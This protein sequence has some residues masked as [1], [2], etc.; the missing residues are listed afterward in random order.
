MIQR[1]GSSKLCTRCTT[2]NLT[3]TGCTCPEPKEVEGSYNSG[4]PTRRPLLVL[5]NSSRRRMTPPPLCQRPRRQEI[6]V[7]HQQ[8]VDEVQSGTGSVCN[9]TCREWGEHHLCP[10]NSTGQG[11]TPGSPTAQV[12]V[13]I[14]SAPRQIPTTGETGWRGP[15]QDPQMAKSSWLKGRNRGLYHRS[16]RSKP[17]NEPKMQTLWPFRR[18]HWP[19]GLRLSWTG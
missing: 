2:P 18:Y 13:D 14:K 4:F 19:S 1:L 15:R 17:P 8:T 5:I 9:T 11:K 10:Q 16:S 6:L 3:W 12:Q 7:L